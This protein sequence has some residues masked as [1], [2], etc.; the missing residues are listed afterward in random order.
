[1]YIVTDS[2]M[3]HIQA[4]T[5]MIVPIRGKHSKD[6]CINYELHDKHVDI[7]SI[8]TAIRVYP[9]ETDGATT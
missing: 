8:G 1:M 4:V 2:S 3:Y 7:V 5:N 6:T 9:V